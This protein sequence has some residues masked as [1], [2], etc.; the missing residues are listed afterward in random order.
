VAENTEENQTNTTH[1]WVSTYPF[2]QTSLHILAEEEE[3]PTSVTLYDPDGREINQL[4]ILYPPFSVGTIEMDEMMG[5]CKLESGLKHAH[6]V[7]TTPRNHS[8]MCRLN[9]YNTS[10]ILGRCAAITSEY[11]GFLPI[12]LSESRTPLIA[13]VN[14]T[15]LD[16]N[17]RCKLFTGTRALEVI[18]NVPGNGVRLISLKGDFKDLVESIKLPTFGYLKLIVRETDASIGVQLV[19]QSKEEK[20]GNIFSSLT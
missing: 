2:F 12:H 7:V 13:L 5:A 1:F 8:C 16:T 17:V 15:P 6:L 19:E 3:K 9:G 10:V 20:V 4:S 11:P 18:R 14:Q